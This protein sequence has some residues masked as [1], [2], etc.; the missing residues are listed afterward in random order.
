MS[1]PAEKFN[2]THI[3]VESS[4]FGCDELRS[5]I[6]SNLALCNADTLDCLICRDSLTVYDSFPLIN[7][8]M[9]Q[10]PNPYSEQLTPNDYEPPHVSI[11]QIN[12]GWNVLAIYKVIINRNLFS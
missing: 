5:Y 12:A 9:F 10:S 8:L 1:L 2:S 3:A 6:L 7:G 11:K 4:G